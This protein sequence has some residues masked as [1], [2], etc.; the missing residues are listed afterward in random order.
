MSIHRGTLYHLT[1]KQ[2]PKCFIPLSASNNFLKCIIIIWV[3]IFSC[4][5]WSLSDMLDDI[6][7]ITRLLSSIWHWYL[8][9]TSLLMSLLITR[10]IWFSRTYN[11]FFFRTILIFQYQSKKIGS[12]NLLSSSMLCKDIFIFTHCNL[13]TYS[14]KD[15]KY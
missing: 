12:I 7:Y 5:V 1:T 8:V 6:T 4:Y 11:I 3:S 2:F 9:L 10:W 14:S 13:L 15:N